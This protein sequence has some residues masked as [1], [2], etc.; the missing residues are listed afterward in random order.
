MLRQS[1]NSIFEMSIYHMFHL[2]LEIV[3]GGGPRVV[4]SNLAPLPF[5]AEFGVRFP[6]S[7]V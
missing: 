7:A 2:K 4:V 3:F 5:T 6:I 1:N